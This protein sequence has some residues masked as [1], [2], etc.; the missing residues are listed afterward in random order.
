[1]VRGEVAGGNRRDL[2]NA[3]IRCL[4]IC[5]EIDSIRSVAF[6]CIST[7]VFGYPAAE[8]AKTALDTVSEWLE[9]NRESLDLV[10]F[11]VFLDKDRNIYESLLS[12]F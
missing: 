11:D 9:N 2:A 10:V 7:G 4:D 5:R 1:M 3:Y 8:A 12:G 6:C